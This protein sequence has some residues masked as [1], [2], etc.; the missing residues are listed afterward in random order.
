MEPMRQR[1]N[2][3][4]QFSSDWKTVSSWWINLVT[5][6]PGDIVSGENMFLL[7]T[8]TDRHF[9]MQEKRAEKG[10]ALWLSTKV[11]WDLCGVGRR[12]VPDFT[13][14]GI[15]PWSSWV[16]YLVPLFLPV[17]ARPLVFHRKLLFMEPQPAD[18]QQACVQQT[19]IVCRWQ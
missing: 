2:L 6:F 8:G 18:G 16:F 9:V 13:A 3:V 15:K 10:A 7:S 4:S 12:W 5:L 19:L 17:M 11:K 1:S 14:R